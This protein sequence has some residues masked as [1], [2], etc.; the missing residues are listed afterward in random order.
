MITAV[1]QSC[2]QCGK[3]FEIRSHY[4]PDQKFCCRKCQRNNWQQAHKE[5]MAAAKKK[6]RAK[7]ETKAMEL[8]YKKTPSQRIKA[9]ERR[10]TEKY[11]LKANARKRWVMQNDPIRAARERG[12]K[13]ISR[14]KPSIKE[15][16]K[17]NRP[18]YRMR[19]IQ[20]L[21]DGYIKE[22]IKTISKNNKIEIS[23]EMIEQKKLTIKLKRKIHEIKQQL[24]PS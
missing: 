23:P 9:K 1:I 14:S 18:K 7:P 8:A 10:K 21:T 20:N 19:Q 24:N 5:Y 4:R 22:I 15:R 13:K 16:I 11:R 6:Y 2:K 17:R 12:Y 3:E